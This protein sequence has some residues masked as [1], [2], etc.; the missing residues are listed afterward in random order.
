LK[1]NN[2]LNI[3]PVPNDI[4]VG[5]VTERKNEKNIPV[6]EKLVEQTAK[7][8]MNFVF[9]KADGRNISVKNFSKV[10]ENEIIPGLIIQKNENGI[11]TINRT[12]K[13]SE[14]DIELEKNDLKIKILTDLR[15]PS[16]EITEEE[17]ME[18]RFCHDEAVEKQLNSIDDNMLNDDYSLKAKIKKE[19]NYI[20]KRNGSMKRKKL[21][22]N[23]LKQMLKI[24]LKTEKSNLI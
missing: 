4:N 11:S 10:N 13:D 16:R 3:F 20:L 19:R 14:N 2:I 12:S 6:E 17:I 21:L 24:Y 15:S 8:P 7:P 5:V 9:E 22:K 1:D 23:F 18:K